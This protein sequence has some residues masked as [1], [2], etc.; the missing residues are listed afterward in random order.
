MPY[1]YRVNRYGLGYW[2]P[3]G[4]G[5][6]SGF[7]TRRVP[8][9]ART[10]SRPYFS[11]NIT[12]RYGTRGLKGLVRAAVEQKY[13]DQALGG[14]DGYAIPNTAWL[15]GISTDIDQ[16]TT[17]VTRIGDKLTLNSIQI[18]GRIDC[19][20]ADP[21]AQYD[22]NTLRLI[23]FKWYDDATPTWGTLMS[24][25]DSDGPISGQFAPHLHYNHDYKA[26]RKILLDKTW[27]VSQ[28]MA[29]A[30]NGSAIVPG[31]Y[32]NSNSRVIINEYID[33]KRM[34]ERDR[35]V[36]FYGGTNEGNGHIY[37]AAVTE[38]PVATKSCKLWLFF[39]TNYT[40]V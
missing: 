11:R 25:T 23:V 33:M 4:Y 1:Q 3:T 24:T 40:D 28:G 19:T 15:A 36:N 6:R 5:R 13:H 20:D 29:V 31:L 16:G 2:R 9:F 10:S 34:K 21:N 12:R 30:Y 27:T 14:A 37:V 18:R 39:R 35:A 26:K 17:D 32:P 7:K 22:I 38:S 8:Q